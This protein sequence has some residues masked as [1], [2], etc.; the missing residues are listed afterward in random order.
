[1]HHNETLFP[2]SHSFIP[3]RW[4]DNPKAPLLNIMPPSINRSDSGIANLGPEI[5][6]S[7]TM[8]TLSKYVVSFS[9]GSRQC[10]G[11]NLAYAELYIGLATIF[12]RVKMRLFET[13]PTQL[14]SRLRVCSP[15]RERIERC[16][17]RC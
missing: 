17:G 2:D 12:R 9:K 16:A 3:E 8:I 15:A 5:D 7:S 6:K 11:M 10:I 1:M 4:L 14:M 13:G